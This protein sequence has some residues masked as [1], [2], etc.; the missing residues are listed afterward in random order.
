MMSSGRFFVKRLGAIRSMTV[1]PGAGRSPSSWSA[2]PPDSSSSTSSPF[3]VSNLGPLPGGKGRGRGKGE[4]GS[5]SDL[6]SGLRAGQSN[7]PGDQ[8]RSLGSAQT[9]AQSQGPRSSQPLQ[10]KNET[11]IPRNQGGQGGG[12]LGKGSGGS[13]GNKNNNSGNNYGKSQPRNNNGKSN[14]NGKGGGKG[15]SKGGSGQPRNGVNLSASSPNPRGPGSPN[16]GGGLS[17][18]GR[19]PNGGM[20]ASLPLES[21]NPFE[22]PFA[23]PVD[24]WPDNGRDDLSDITGDDSGLNPYTNRQA[25]GAARPGGTGRFKSSANGM[26]RGGGKGARYG[27]K[28]KGGNRDSKKPSAAPVEVEKKVALPAGR[29]VKVNELAALARLK[30]A[31][32]ITKL[33]SVLGITDLEEDD[34]A[35]RAN[36]TCFFKLPRVIVAWWY[37]RPFLSDLIHPD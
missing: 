15:G 26:A 36:H 12:G 18:S 7:G 3:G 31:D 35:V 30:R 13:N 10:S 28:G 37:L 20:A 33:E 2:L 16:R 21:S 14:N 25:R 24:L 22:N 17:Q 27:G 34:A 32:V 9:N 29:K 6:A 23:P 4:A 11:R 5:L 1:G 8:A 19:G